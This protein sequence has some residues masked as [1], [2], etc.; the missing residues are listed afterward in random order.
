MTVNMIV[1]LEVGVTVRGMPLLRCFYEQLLRFDF[2]SE[3]AV[4]STSATPAEMHQDGY[5][6]VRL[7]NNRSDQIKLEMA[8]R[9]VAQPSPAFV[10]DRPADR[11]FPIIVQDTQAVTD[12][13]LA[14][15]VNFLNGFERMEARLGVD[16]AFD[17]GFEGNVLEIVQCS[18]IVSYP[19]D[20]QEKH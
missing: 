10:L 5:T 7:Q 2:V 20:L 11:Y 4:A 12:Q 13:P 8:N 16:V 6:A 17:H 18:D 14:A 19:P 9:A 1:P 3:M 15:N